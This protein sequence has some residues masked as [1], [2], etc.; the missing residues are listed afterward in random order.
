MIV[1]PNKR[2]MTCKQYI[3][4]EDGHVHTV[5]TCIDGHVDQM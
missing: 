5:N 3:E 2:Y 4:G 1:Q